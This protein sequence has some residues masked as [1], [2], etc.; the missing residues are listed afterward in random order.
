LRRCDVSAKAKLLY[1]ALVDMCG[2]GFTCSHSQ[3]YIGSKVGGL[4]RTQLKICFNELEGI[5]L[6]TAK[7]T[8]QNSIYTLRLHPILVDILYSMERGRDG[9]PALA[10]KPANKTLMV[11]GRKTVPLSDRHT[12]FPVPPDADDGKVKRAE[13]IARAA[14]NRAMRE[15]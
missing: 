6:I 15:M 8:M 14:F 13:M 11:K 4:K 5:G 9:K 3:Q 2:N 10:G 7:K 12:D 1:I